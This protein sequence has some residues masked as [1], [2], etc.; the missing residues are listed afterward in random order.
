MVINIP[1]VCNPVD[2]SSNDRMSECRALL[3]ALDHYKCNV[4]LF[5]NESAEL[6]ALDSLQHKVTLELITLVEGLTVGTKKEEGV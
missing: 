4:A 1:I 2:N 3:N 6:Y 5:N